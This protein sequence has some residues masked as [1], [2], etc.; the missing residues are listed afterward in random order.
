MSKIIKKSIVGLKW[1]S[2]RKVGK[3]ILNLAITLILVQFLS[4]DAFGMVAMITVFS[5]LYMLFSDLGLGSSIIQKEDLSEIQVSTV[6]WIS[7]AI[8]FVS[9]IVLYLCSDL[10]ASFYALD[11]LADMTKVISFSLFLG[12][13]VSIPIALLNKELDFKRLC[14]IDLLALDLSGVLAILAAINS[15]GVWSLVVLII[16]NAIFRCLGVLFLTSWRPKF[17]YNI[18]SIKPLMHFGVFFTSNNVL[19]YSIRNLDDL[20]IGKF[21]GSTELGLYSKAYSLLLLPLK[22]ITGVFQ[23][24]LFPTFSKLQSDPNQIRDVYLKSVSGIAL[25]S[26]PLMVIIYFVCDELIELF[27]TEEWY[28]IIPLVKLFCFLGI[29][30]SILRITGSLFL[31]MNKTKWLFNFNLVTS[32]IFFTGFVFVINKGIIA[33]AYWWLFYSIV[34]GV[35]QILFSNYIIGLDTKIYVSNLLPI[36]L[37]TGLVFGLGMLIDTQLV[38][39]NGLVKAILIGM[40]LLLFYLLLL[41]FTNN[42][43]F[44][45]MR[46]ILQRKT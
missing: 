27:F 43:T 45:S 6:Y 33:I 3:T 13:I 21:L 22:N 24:V 39:A 38:I 7:S 11:E 5:G 4:P 15:Y 26:F 30:Q 37:I 2:I 35:F 34:I 40:L 36:S 25:I 32:V 12:G 42:A 18:D 20:L 8:G 9:M 41:H 19:N 17:T 44:K 31:A 16:A 14:I 1:N 28:S 10:L 29:I 23:N 46:R